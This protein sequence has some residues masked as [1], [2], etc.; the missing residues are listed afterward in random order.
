MKFKRIIPSNCKFRVIN[1]R[2]VATTSS[3]QLGAWK[4]Y[5]YLLQSS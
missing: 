1:R 3:V 4:Y 5:Y 2:L